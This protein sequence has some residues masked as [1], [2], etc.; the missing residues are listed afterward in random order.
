MVSEGLSSSEPQALEIV[1]TII[2]I[3]TEVVGE[4]L[5]AIIKSATEED[6]KNQPFPNPLSPEEEEWLSQAFEHF[7]NTKKNLNK[8]EGGHLY[9]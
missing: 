5:E 3:A 1:Q 8:N 9:E 4:D 2:K 7:E 6:L